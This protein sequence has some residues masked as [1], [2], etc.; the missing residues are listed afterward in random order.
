[1][2]SLKELRNRIASVKTI[3]PAVLARAANVVRRASG[4]VSVSRRAGALTRLLGDTLTAQGH[5]D[6][7]LCNG[8]DSLCGS[9]DPSYLNTPSDLD[10]IA[11]RLRSLGAGARL[12]LH[13]PPGTG[14]T[15]FGH[16]LASELDRPLFARKASDL[17]GKY[18][19]ETEERIGE[20][21]E[22]ATRDKAI[23]LIDEVDSFLANREGAQRS[24]EITCVNEMLT[25]IESF[26][27]IL[28]ATTNRLEALDPASLR[29]FDLKVGFDYLRGD[30]VEALL[31]AQCLHLGF[32]RP[33]RETLLRAS[34]LTTCTPG[35]FAA[36]ARR[37]RFD[38]F[39]DAGSLIA[40]VQEEIRH[41]RPVRPPIGFA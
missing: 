8:R 18:V 10:A 34:R 19:G 3:A 39:H 41:R 7:F 16:W 36:V 29:R 12:C 30:Q 14:K 6:P 1:M 33:D 35:D 20:A 23:L 15:A 5:P 28:I 2:A 38:P 21:F 25:R 4:E 9:Y 31:V 11:R 22:E 32:S 37:H 27:G 13:G 17:L 40:A 26:P 24:W